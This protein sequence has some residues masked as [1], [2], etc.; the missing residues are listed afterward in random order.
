MA[1]LKPGLRKALLAGGIAVT[2]T[3]AGGAAVW[4]G[5][6]SPSGTQGPSAT[7]SSSASAEPSQ[8][9]PSQTA[10]GQAIH[11]EHVVKQPDGSY[12]T[13]L[14]QAGTIDSVSGSDITVKSEDGFTQGYAITTDTRIARIP[15]D[16]SELRNSNGNSKSKPALPSV[17]AAEL[18]A[19][20]KVHISGIKDGGTVTATKIVAGELP[21]G[22][23]GG[24]GLTGGH[25][26]MGGHRGLGPRQATE[27]RS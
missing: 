8:A 12:R 20:D 27:L 22:I 19:G 21:T 9:A 6:Q 4:A 2:L 24:H 13:V 16:V 23:K 3:C 25:G 11:G 15:A 5:T 17:T 14:T 10:R 1:T 7:P 26:L 18:K